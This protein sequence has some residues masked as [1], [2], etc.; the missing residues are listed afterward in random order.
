MKGL[1]N[2]GTAGHE[3]FIFQLGSLVR[4]KVYVELGLIHCDLFNRMDSVDDQLI[5]VDINELY[6]KF[7]ERSIFPWYYAGIC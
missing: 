5:G 6:E 1:S 2:V 3:D 7:G 4:P